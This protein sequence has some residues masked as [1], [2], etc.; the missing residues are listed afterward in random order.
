MKK[1]ILL[2]SCFCAITVNAQFTVSSDSAYL[3]KTDVANLDALFLFNGISSFTEI[4]YTGNETV[5]EWQTF[6]G[7][8]YSNSRTISPEDATGYTLKIN[9]VITYHI[10]TINYAAYPIS[11]GAL[12]IVEADDRCDY[13]KLVP[14]YTAPDLAYQDKNNAT[15]LLPRVFTF[16]YDA[17][18]FANDVWTEPAVKSFTKADPFTEVVLPAPLCNTKFSMS[19][20][21][22]AE[23]MNISPKIVE[24]NLYQAISVKSNMKGTVSERTAKNEVDR[25]GTDISGSGPLVVDFESRVNPISTVFYEWYVYNL[26]E[27]N[28]YIR[29]NDR[30]LR[31]TFTESGSYRVKLVA[32]SNSCEYVDSLDVR[33]LASSLQVPN[34]FTP[35][36]DGINDEFR[37]V[38]KSLSSYSCTVFNRWGRTVFSSDD[39]GK[40]WDGLVNGKMAAPG[41]YYYVIHATGTDLDSKGNPLKYKLSGDINLLRGK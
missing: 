29:Y 38:F 23:Q 30:D 17:V 4:T 5:L 19:G 41:A 26:A 3:Q 22:Y 12:E 7:V 36:G 34:V 8:F 31:Y 10:W 33:V 28:N 24:T 1:L 25:S 11:I 27:P 16:R 39:P 37:V 15:H 40:G 2:L 18:E 14:T 21:M 35:N 13:I 6:D 20:D 32:A 9:G